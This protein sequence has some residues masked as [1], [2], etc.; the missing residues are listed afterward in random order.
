MG[1]SMSDFYAKPYGGYAIGSTQGNT[2]CYRT[3]DYLTASGYARNC[4][5]GILGNVYGESA[6]NPWLWENNTYNLNNG[7]GLFQYTP[8]SDYINATS[9]PDHAPNLST[10]I[11][12]PGSDPDDAKGQLYA[13]VHDSFGKWLSSCWR[14]YWSISDYPALYAMRQHII[15]TYGNGS[16]L[17]QSQFASIDNYED[18]CFAFLACFEGP[19]VPNY[20]TR[21]N[22]AQQIKPIIDAYAVDFDIL[23]LKKFFIDRQFKKYYN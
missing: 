17:T 22:Y 12:T 18:A 3:Y 21:V 15:T 9:I 4:I 1:S 10:S 6:L 2:N 23:F 16:S 13:F 7:Y 19:A 20:S 11:Q 5:I 8:A 14:S